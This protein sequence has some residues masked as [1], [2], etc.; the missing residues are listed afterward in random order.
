M[1]YSA[2]NRS[3]LCILY[4]VMQSDRF[5]NSSK[6]GPFHE[7]TTYKPHVQTSSD[8]IM[9]FARYEYGRVE[10]FRTKIRPLIQKLQSLKKCQFSK[11]SHL[12]ASHCISK[13]SNT[14]TYFNDYFLLVFIFIFKMNQV[15]KYRYSSLKILILSCSIRIY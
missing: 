1:P 15:Y 4:T 13:L 2:I 5:K 11:C 7:P 6:T 12:I 14:D 9:T 10:V 3:N 8:L